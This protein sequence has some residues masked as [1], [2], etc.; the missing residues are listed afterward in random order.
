MTALNWWDCNKNASNRENNDN[1]FSQ[2]RDLNFS[3]F[4]TFHSLF[5]SLPKSN[6]NNSFSFVS[7]HHISLL[8]FVHLKWIW[9]IEDKIHKLLK[10]FHLSRL[11]IYLDKIQ[12]LNYWNLPHFASYAIHIVYVLRVL[13]SSDILKS[14]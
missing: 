11:S 10:P 5:S 12:N 1:F 4:E 3:C 14:V 8:A 7:I 9:S 2:T 13:C 6:I